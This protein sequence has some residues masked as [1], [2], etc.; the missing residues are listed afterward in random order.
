VLAQLHQRVARPSRR[1]RRSTTSGPPLKLQPTFERARSRCGT[2]TRTRTITATRSTRSRR[3]RRFALRAARAVSQRA[4]EA[5]AETVRGRLQDLHG[6]G[7]RRPSAPVLNNLGVV[8]LRPLRPAQSGLPVYFFFQGRQGGPGRLGL[9]VQPGLRLLAD[10]DTRR[11]STGCARPSR[12]T[13][14]T[15]MRT[16]CS[17]RRLAASATARKP[18]ASTNW[19]AASRRS[20]RSWTNEDRRRTWSTACP[21]VSSG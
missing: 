16:S 17:A 6:V 3:S 4:R 7:R 11:R 2:S 12:A 8:Q 9:R 21:A 1:K 13:A 19:P 14:P 10:R 20:T 5:R 18:C 15:P